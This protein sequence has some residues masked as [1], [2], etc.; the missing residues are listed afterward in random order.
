M[1]CFVVPNEC[2]TFEIIIITRTEFSKKKYICSLLIICHF[3][4]FI[5]KYYYL[6]TMQN[7]FLNVQRNFFV[8]SCCLLLSL[9]LCETW[10]PPC[11]YIDAFALTI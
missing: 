9:I 8:S 5:L 7:V 6:N 3:L 2:E 4:S 10:G 1:L 11:G